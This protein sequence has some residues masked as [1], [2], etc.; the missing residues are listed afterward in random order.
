V[1]T[2]RCHGEVTRSVL[3]KARGDVFAGFHAVAAKRRSRIRNSQFGLMRPVLRAT[4]T[5]VYMAAPVRNILDTT[6]YT[7]GPGSPI[8]MA[9]DYRL[10]GPGIESQWG[11]NFSHTSR[12]SLGPTQSPVQWVPHLSRG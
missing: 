1:K 10:D 6:S 9:N 11:R 2:G 3:A 8:G 12:T 5:A 4:T 7:S